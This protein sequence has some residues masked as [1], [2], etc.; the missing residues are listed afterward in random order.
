VISPAHRWKKGFRISQVK[1][2]LVQRCFQALDLR[3][4]VPRQLLTAGS[5]ED[6]GLGFESGSVPG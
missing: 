1:V 2:D 4:L 5:L 3:E 6:F